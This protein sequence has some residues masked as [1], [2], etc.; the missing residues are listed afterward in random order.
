[1]IN[2]YFFPFYFVYLYTGT[3]AIH[4]SPAYG[5][6][7]SIPLEK[8]YFSCQT[9]AKT[10]RQSSVSDNQRYR[11]ANTKSSQKSSRMAQNVSEL[12]AS[13]QRKTTFFLHIQLIAIVYAK[14]YLLLFIHMDVSSLLVLFKETTRYELAA[15]VPSIEDH[16][17]A[18]RREITNNMAEAVRRSS[19]CRCR[20]QHCP[21]LTRMPMPLAATNRCATEPQCRCHRIHK[22]PPVSPLTMPRLTPIRPAMTLPRTWSA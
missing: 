12:S 16:C 20:W 7:F 8:K 9:L 15:I 18:H 17:T 19:R 5:K 1:M 10:N 4:I 6:C 21:L 13:M 14:N 11:N 2:M 3:P 22:P